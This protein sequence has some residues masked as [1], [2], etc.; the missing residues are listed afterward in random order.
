ML[1]EIR[2]RKIRIAL[3]VFMISLFLSGLTAIPLIPELEWVLSHSAMKSNYYDWIEKVLIAL[4]DTNS[5]YPFVFYGF[6]WLAFAHFVL[7]ILFIGPYRDPVKNIWVLEF[8]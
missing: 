1:Q 4:K 2:L 8:G 6:D 3:I 5:K 7:T